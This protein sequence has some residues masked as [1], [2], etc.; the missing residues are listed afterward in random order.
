MNAGLSTFAQA[1]Q[2]M[3]VAPPDLLASMEVEQ[4]NLL[5]LRVFVEALARDDFATAFALLADE[6]SYALCGG[7]ATPF[8]LDGDGRAAVEAGI[9]ANFG[10]V[11][12]EAVEIE[13]LVAQGD[14]IVAIERERGHWRASGLP[15][16]QRML[17][18]YTFTQGK[19]R[20]YRGW[21]LPGG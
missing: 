12:F 14:K 3:I 11:D 19:L 9:L 7:G 4:G 2:E 20:T 18:E 21:V 13:T 10:A 5:C 8:Q 17:L 16:D 15:F 6:V 1:L